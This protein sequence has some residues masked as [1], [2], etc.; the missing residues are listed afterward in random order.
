MRR[1]DGARGR[2]RERRLRLVRTGYRASRGGHD[3][4]HGASLSRREGGT[5]EGERQGTLMRANAAGRRV[6]CERRPA[7]GTTVVRVSAY[8]RMYPGTLQMGMQISG[9]ANTIPSSF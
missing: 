4:R 5:R 1:R 6:A 9:H 2:N 7:A 8:V 3:S